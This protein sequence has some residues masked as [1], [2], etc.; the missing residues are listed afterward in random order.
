MSRYTIKATVSVDVEVSVEASSKSDASL[1]FHTRLELHA[2]LA[3][4]PQNEF[5]VWDECIS[6]VNNMRIEAVW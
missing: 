1:L 3:N 5:D 6:E 4:T 2:S